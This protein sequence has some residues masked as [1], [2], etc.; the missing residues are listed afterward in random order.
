MLGAI[1]MSVFSLGYLR[2]GATDLDAWRRFGIDTVGFMAGQSTDESLWLRTDDRPFR[3]RIEKSSR[4]GLLAPG[5]ELPDAVSYGNCLTALRKAGV[6]VT[7]GTDSDAAARCVN[8]FSHASDPAGNRFELYWGRYRSY[9]PFVSPR[10]LSGFV[11][12]DLGAG[13]VVLPA[14]E[15]D[16]VH[17][18]YRDLLG[19]GD[20]DEMRLTISP[21]PAVPQL[22]ILFMH[23]TCRRH[24]SL[25][26]IPMPAPSGLV[27]T[28]VEV[29]SV[30]DVGRALDRCVAAGYH[31]SSSLGR[32]SNDDMLGFYVAT[33]GGFDLE[34]GC[35][36]LVPDWSSWIPTRSLVPSIWGHKWSPPPG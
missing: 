7:P 28:M 18:F 10:G 24:H 21:D 34:I 4:D 23:A 29:R 6:I 33:P 16:K 8:G 32:H 3:F 5:W 9:E 20:T 19:F 17:D 26:L 15:I 12:G 27:H 2:I 1:L 31:I 14:P 22:R 11:T 25:A 36:G 13:H 30:D 35:M